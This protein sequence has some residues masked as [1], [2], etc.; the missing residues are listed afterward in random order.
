LPS[1]IIGIIK[2][3]SFLIALDESIIN[4]E[5]PSRTWLAHASNLSG[6]GYE[7]LSTCIYKYHLH[8]EQYDGIAS[9]VTILTNF[10][11]YCK[12][13][14]LF[15]DPYYSNMSLYL[16]RPN[17]RIHL[18]FNCQGYFFDFNI[19]SVDPFERVSETPRKLL[20]PEKLIHNACTEFKKRKYK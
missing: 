20:S 12:N 13:N 1:S 9:Y 11:K 16:A 6:K 19:I 14:Y 3:Y 10:Y 8:P 2:Y 7:T 5:H 18:F 17:Q 4:Q 15:D